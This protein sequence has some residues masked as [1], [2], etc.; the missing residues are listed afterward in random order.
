MSET[1]TS[2]PSPPV[3]SPLTTSDANHA[4]GSGNVHHPHSPQNPSSSSSKRRASISRVLAVWCALTS[5]FLGILLGLLLYPAQRVAVEKTAVEQVGL[6]AQA[7]SAVYS[8]GDVKQEST[9]ASSGHRVNIMLAEMSRIPNLKYIDVTDA[10]GVVHKSTKADRVGM[11]VQ[12]P[13]ISNQVSADAD[14]N[15]EFVVVSHAVPWN[16]SCM[17][18][19]KADDN[20]NPRTYLGSVIV[21]VD[22]KP[23]LA[24]FD[25]FN[26]GLVIAIIGEIIL[27]TIC[28]LLYTNYL[29]VKP[30]KSLM[31]IMDE[32]TR[33][34][35]HGFM[36]RAPI[37]R[38]DEV[39]ALAHAFNRML[40]AITSMQAEGIEHEQELRRAAAELALKKDL[41]RRVKAQELLM[42]AAHHLGSTLSRNHVLDR[43][44]QLLVTKLN[45][46]N[47]AVFLLDKSAIRTSEGSHE[48][49]NR[50]ILVV[51][52][53]PMMGTGLS[54][55]S[56]VLHKTS[57]KN[58]GELSNTGSGRVVA[59]SNDLFL[60]PQRLFGDRYLDALY[61]QP[62]RV[63]EGLVGSVA[64]S[65]MAFYSPDLS[66]PMHTPTWQELGQATNKDGSPK[67][68]PSVGSLIA[69]PIA[70]K[71]R[72][73]GVL[74]VYEPDAKAFDA[75][76]R[77]LLDALSALVG[78]TLINA[79]LY[80]TTLEMSNTDPL[81]GLMNR[82]ALERH[83]HAEAA[84]ALRFQVPM[85]VLMIDV[86]HFK[87][88]NDRMGHLLGDEALRGIAQAL[89]TCLRKVDAVAR[90]GGEEFCVIL[91]RTDAEAAADVAHKLQSAVQ[92]LELPGAA[93]QPLGKMSV[94]IGVACYPHDVPNGT[95]AA[96]AARA[97]LS[98]ALSG[99]AVDA[100]NEMRLAKMLLSTADEAAYLAKH[101]G[102]ACVCTAAELAERTDT[103]A[104]SPV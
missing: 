104:E 18:C 38:Q 17:V 94:S 11:R 83:L 72:F 63:G 82:R 47:F 12:N 45:Y 76:T 9:G 55:L 58:A 98:Q 37:E 40:Q 36:L 77:A 6:L 84:R 61:Q 42:E 14:I 67:G 57:N 7:V 8:G 87:K 91:P 27:M 100:P 43:L 80:G 46:Q 39:G 3:V 22:R 69:L 102:R 10:A 33:S 4:V 35:N 88:Y 71:T 73:L 48:G 68:L 60:Q 85:A 44:A 31:F 25:D 5:T 62:W 64:S 70:Q 97:L 74:V 15:K 34:G 53:N 23:T 16:G 52:E 78:L 49:S 50:S 51:A 13:Q 26:R 1:P 24:G 93:G 32:T 103:P 81:T 20:G 28:L 92:A 54:S 30:I 19:H 75:D 66:Q 56:S 79:E 96:A 2:P 99:E 21:A 65:G 89:S 41:E 86:D 95:A 90:Y 59:P 29:V 101:R